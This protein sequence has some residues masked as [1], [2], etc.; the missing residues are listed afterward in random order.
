M[1]WVTKAEGKQYSTYWN[2]TP[3]R[4]NNLIH[5]TKKIKLQTGGQKIKTKKP[6]KCLEI[7]ID[8]Y[9]SFKTENYASW[10]LHELLVSLLNLDIMFH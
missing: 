6:T 10:K 4:Q 1:S 8:E 5:V 3:I 9:L 7:I 2:N